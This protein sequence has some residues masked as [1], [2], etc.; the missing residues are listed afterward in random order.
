LNI[1]GAPS[2]VEVFEDLMGGDVAICC[3]AMLE[4]GVVLFV[5]GVA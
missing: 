5:K 4:L 3:E 2:E 1:E